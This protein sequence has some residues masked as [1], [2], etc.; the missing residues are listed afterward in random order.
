MELENHYE[1]EH[2]NISTLK[3]K[4]KVPKERKV[5]KK[6]R[7]V[8]PNKSNYDDEMDESDSSDEISA[9]W[10]YDTENDEEEEESLS[11]YAQLFAGHL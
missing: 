8:A 5:V 11:E 6:Q 4:R 10:K 7:I 3:R 9:T 1:E 2:P